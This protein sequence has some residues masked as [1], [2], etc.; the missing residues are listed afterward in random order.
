MARGLADNRS[1]LPIPVMSGPQD[2]SGAT[3]VAESRPAVPVFGDGGRGTRQR[4]LRYSGD[5]INCCSSCRWVQLFFMTA[6]TQDRAPGSGSRPST[7]R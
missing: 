6:S 1:S 7:E 5:F 2:S 3:G 4:L